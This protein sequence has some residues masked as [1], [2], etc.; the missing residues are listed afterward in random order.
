MTTEEKQMADNYF[1]ILQEHGGVTTIW[2]DQG[3]ELG[4]GQPFTVGTEGDER[5]R[6]H[7]VSYTPHGQP[8]LNSLY[9]VITAQGS[10]VS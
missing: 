7:I 2:V 6:R 8:F 3:I 5:N 9:H 4:G 1:S 10:A